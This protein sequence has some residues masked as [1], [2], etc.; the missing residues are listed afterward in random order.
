MLG[1]D[2]PLT[3]TSASHLAADLRA[4]GQHEAANQLDEDTETRRR[5]LATNQSDNTCGWR[6]V[7]GTRNAENSTSS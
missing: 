6:S 3:L 4:L 7:H 5:A 2:H 1:A